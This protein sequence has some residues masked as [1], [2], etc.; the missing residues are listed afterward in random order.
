MAPLSPNNVVPSDDVGGSI[1][2]SRFEQAEHEVRIQ[3]Y[4]RTAVYGVVFMLLGMSLDYFVFRQFLWD[5]LLVRSL[6][7]IALGIT[8]LLLRKFQS[9]GQVRVIVQAIAI[10]PTISILWMIHCT[11][12]AMSEYYA[13]LNLVLVA[14][15]LM[16]RWSSQEC[17]LNAVMIFVAYLVVV[18]FGV[19][20]TRTFFNNAYFI[21]VTA[22]FTTAGCYY[23]NMLRF[24][25]FVL[26]DELE[27]NRN[28]LEQQNNQ[29]VQLDE[30]KTRFFANISHELRTPLTLI[31]GPLDR[32]KNSPL[33]SRDRGLMDLVTTLE[34]NGFRLLR[35]IN[36]LLDLVRLDGGQMTMH[37]SRVELMPMFS[38]I[39]ENIRGLADS[40]QIEIRSIWEGDENAV[41]HI[42]RDAL[43]KVLL[44]L[45]VNAVKFTPN[46][47]RVTIH[48]GT[49]GT[50]ALRFS[51]TDTGPG[52]KAEDLANIFKRF[53]QADTSRKRKHGGVGIGLSLA[54][55]LVNSMDGR[56]WAE[57]EEGKGAKFTVELPIELV[58]RASLIT[59][60]P[61]EHD[62]MSG[63]AAPALDSVEGLYQRARTV[64]ITDT[65][66]Q[67]SDQSF[68]PIADPESERRRLVLVADDEPSLRRYL[69]SLLKEYRVIEAKDGH[70]AWEMARQ[71]RPDL[72]ILDLMMP[73]LDGI[74]VTRRL[75]AM[76]AT[77]RT[78]IVLVTANA[79]SKPKFEALEAGASEFLT[80]PFASAELKARLDNLF[81]QQDY[82]SALESAKESLEHANTSLKENE[83]QLVQSERLSGLGRMS[84]GII[85]EINNP[86]NYARTA[87]YSLRSFAKNVSEDERED[88][89]ETVADIS[90]GVDRVIRIV[91]DLRSFTKGNP[92]SRDEHSFA[93]IIE[94]AMR[95]SSDKLSNVRVEVSIPEGTLIWGNDSQLVQIFVNLFNNAAD[96]SQAAKTRGEEPRIDVRAM[97]S[98]GGSVEITFRDNGSG[99][100]HDDLDKLFDPF[101]TKRD[102]GEGT[103]LG[104]SIVHQI[105]VAHQAEISVNS[106]VNRFTEFHFC[107]P[108]RPTEH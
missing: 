79:E 81:R 20:E 97:T 54:N 39:A 31:L 105:C 30:A 102:V 83:A 80:K 96:F 26:R 37:N 64:G 63:A 99:I 59:Y 93:K 62:A 91:S 78:P 89:M 101:F 86:L 33:I 27:S 75:R 60:L 44:N 84:A 47:G 69:L 90:E 108:K 10:L 41:A 106:E 70:E 71:Y 17:A 107:F 100:Q 2:V 35:L 58:D 104:L 25:E 23:Y 55:D 88:F 22:I 51:V 43:E 48:A 15:S 52:I 77:A 56:I 74:E 65:D 28:L 19:V 95:L 42:N 3:N 5:F 49:V 67:L 8:V 36:E 103:G 7:A 87:A 98:R 53:W 34:E 46:F 32:L 61:E 92:T 1:L 11:G 38:S 94:L 66:D 76:P 72:I 12:G 82:A 9:V 6:C 68:P 85:H 4:S 18:S 73:E 14:V 40:K 45:C 24:K 29:L 16:L 57:S 13:G 50:T 21:F